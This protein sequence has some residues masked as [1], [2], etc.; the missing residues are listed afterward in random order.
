MILR[1]IQKIFTGYH[2]LDNKSFHYIFYILMGL[3]VTDLLL[4]N[5]SLSGFKISSSWGVTTFIVLSIVFLIGQYLILGFV[6][7]KSKSISTKSAIIDKLNKSILIIQSALA[8]II[9]V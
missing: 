9:L 4:S 7:N 8:G 1:I 5:I 2:D 3:L 6:I